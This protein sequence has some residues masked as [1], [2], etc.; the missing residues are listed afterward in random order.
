MN[1]DVFE[2]KWK[3]LRGRVKGEWARL[4]DDEIDQ[5]DGDMTRLSGF[6]QEKY[7]KSRAD[8]EK[9]IATLLKH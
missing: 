3:Q 7:G 2:G 5:I 6:I 8:A 4:T 1:A 9:A